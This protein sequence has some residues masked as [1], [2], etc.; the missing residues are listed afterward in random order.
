MGLDHRL[1]RATVGHIHRQTKGIHT[2]LVDQL[3]GR[4]GVVPLQVGRDNPR[5]LVGQAERKGPTDPLTAT[6]NDRHFVT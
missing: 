2:P 4:L 5:P 1:D 3:R 6:G